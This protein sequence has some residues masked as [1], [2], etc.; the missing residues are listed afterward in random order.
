MKLYTGQL[1]TF[2]KMC[3]CTCV[4]HAYVCVCMGV[5]IYVS[6]CVSTCVCLCVFCCFDKQKAGSTVNMQAYPQIEPLCFNHKRT[7]VSI[8]IL[9][10]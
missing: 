3:V 10:I 7:C 9:E 4:W 8:R 2:I 5:C 6:V 1:N